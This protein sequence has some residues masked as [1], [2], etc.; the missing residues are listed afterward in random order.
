MSSHVTCDGY[1]ETVA[2]DD[3]LDPVPELG[4]QPGQ[5][6]PGVSDAAGLGGRDDAGVAI[7]AIVHSQHVVTQGQQ[8][9]AETNPENNMHQQ[10]TTKN[11]PRNVR[12]I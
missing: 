4:G 2:P 12:N 5:R 9:L 10:L 11:L 1:A 8:L 6:R 7:A 3:H